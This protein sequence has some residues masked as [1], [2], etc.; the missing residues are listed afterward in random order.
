M[1]DLTLTPNNAL[2][3]AGQI[4]NREAARGVFSDY[5]TRKTANTLR[6]QRADLALCA[7]FLQ[8]AGLE[9]GDLFGDPGAWEGVTWGLVEGFARWQLREGYAVNSV[10]VRLATVKTYARLALKAGA[11]DAAEMAMI[12]SVKGYGH[13]EGRNLDEK[14]AAADLPTRKGAKKAEPVSLTP[15]QAARL[16]VHPDTP[17]GRRDTLL[18][19]L[20][21]EHGLRV[22]EVAG[23]RV[24]D[25]DLKGGKLKFYRVKVDKTQTHK[26]TPRTLQA[27]QTYFEHDAPAMGSLWRKSAEKRAGKVA[28]GTLTGQG[29]TDRALT[30]RVEALGRGIGVTGLSAHDCRHYWATRAARNGTPIDRLQQAGGW[31][32]P[33]MPLRYVEG[34]KIAN[35]GVRLD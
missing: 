5:Q 11:L 22:G 14:R 35:E 2:A 33:A 30:K 19:C 29:M 3:L 7:A 12:A 4:A 26:L 25:F 1:N 6:R 13:K 31:N 28:R 24:G 8:A 34:A 9:P 21:L 10:N 23:L 18:M 17:Q 15:E 20:M 16:M 27:A 32:S